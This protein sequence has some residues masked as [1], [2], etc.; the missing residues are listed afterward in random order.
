MDDGEIIEVPEGSTEEDVYN[1]YNSRPYEFV[2]EDG[3]IVTAPANTT[4]QQ[5][6]ELFET[7]KQATATNA[8]GQKID[9]PIY[10]NAERMA[11]G[12][13]TLIN[14]N[15]ASKL[16][17]YATNLKETAKTNLA[18]RVNNFLTDVARA[19]DQMTCTQ[20]IAYRHL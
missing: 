11:M 5:V 20:Q 3:S 2:M 15:P 9:N 19:D 1:I 12:D 17:N 10:S 4:S 8:F 14:D 6:V 18:N 13:T 7:Q 16:K